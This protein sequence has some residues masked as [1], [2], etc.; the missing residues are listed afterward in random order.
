MF[1]SE[2]TKHTGIHFLCY[3]DTLVCPGIRDARHQYFSASTQPSQTRHARPKRTDFMGEKQTHIRQSP[4]K[5]PDRATTISLNPPDCATTISRLITK[6]NGMNERSTNISLLISI[7]TIHRAFK[8]A[9]STKM[10]VVMTFVFR[11]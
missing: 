6:C 8:R 1:I 4:L 9:L 5:P 3:E 2:Q 10:N 7:H 11:R